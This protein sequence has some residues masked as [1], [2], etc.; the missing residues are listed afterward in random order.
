[1]DRYPEVAPWSLPAGV[2]ALIVFAVVAVYAVSV[3]LRAGAIVFAAAMAIL[4]AADAWVYATRRRTARR[5]A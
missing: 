5:T 3:P 1:M 4:T 2:A